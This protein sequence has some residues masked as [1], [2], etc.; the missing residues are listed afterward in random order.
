V[1]NITT[2]LGISHY[3]SNPNFTY[4]VSK[5][6]TKPHCEVVP[7]IKQRRVAITNNPHYATKSEPLQLQVKNVQ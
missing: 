6:V 3:S 2:G 7:Q 1:L 5:E 4:G